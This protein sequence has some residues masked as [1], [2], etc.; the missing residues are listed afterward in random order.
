MGISLKKVLAEI[1]AYIAVSLKPPLK[2]TLF[3]S[4][5]VRQLGN[6]N[7]F[8]SV[9]NWLGAFRGVRF[10][11]STLFVGK[12][13]Q[14]ISIVHSGYRMFCLK[15]GFQRTWRHSMRWELL[16]LMFVR[17]LCVRIDGN[18]GKNWPAVVVKVIVCRWFLKRVKSLVFL[19]D[20]PTCECSSNQGSIS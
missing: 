9:P 14:V 15:R 5:H 6:Y 4:R 13:L 11:C 7:D 17:L 18:L 19:I 16:I 12:M 8:V 1:L 3:I 2:Q 10:T 20:Q